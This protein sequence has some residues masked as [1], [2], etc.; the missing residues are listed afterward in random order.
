M[1]PSSPLWESERVE[2]PSVVEEPVPEP[3]VWKPAVSVGQ[4]AT[5]VAIG[6]GYCTGLALSMSIARMTNAKTL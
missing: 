4:R 6:R 2:V 3:K 1:L 5:S